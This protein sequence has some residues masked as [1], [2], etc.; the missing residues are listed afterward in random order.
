MDHPDQTR[1]HIQSKQNMSC[2]FGPYLYLKSYL[3]T[4][5]THKS[6]YNYVYQTY[7]VSL[8]NTLKFYTELG[9]FLAL[10]NVEIY[11]FFYFVS[12]FDTKNMTWFFRT[13]NHYMYLFFRM[14]KHII[15]SML[16]LN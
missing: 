13:L 9:F 6:S 8:F 10:F 1:C 3:S 14:L 4:N 15:D 16:N 11:E 7:L 12:F 5:Y 2:I